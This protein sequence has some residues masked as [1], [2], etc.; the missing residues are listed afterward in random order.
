MA[1]YRTFK[2]Y[3]APD[4]E[5]VVHSWLNGLPK[6]AKVK[7]NALLRRLE[8]V[9]RL[10][11]P[12]VRML[13]GECDGLM[14]LRREAG[15]VQY[16]PICCYDPGRGDVT[17]LTGAVERGGRFVP[18]SACATAQSRRARLTERGRTCDH[19]FG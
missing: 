18:A 6:P 14:E 5:N 19:D 12:E 9:E 4:G 10:E 3:V 8:V 2:D 13:H 17:L 16:R 1:G 15:N 7:I 11:M